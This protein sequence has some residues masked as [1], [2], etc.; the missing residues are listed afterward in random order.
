MLPTPC[1]IQ[2]INIH[3]I[4]ILDFL[5]LS[6]TSPPSLNYLQSSQASSMSLATQPDLHSTC[7][8]VS[9]DWTFW[10]WSTFQSNWQDNKLTGKRYCYWHAAICVS[11]RD[12][13]PSFG[14]TIWS[15]DMPGQKYG[16][17]YSRWSRQYG[18]YTSTFANSRF[19]PRKTRDKVKMVSWE[20]QRCVDVPAMPSPSPL[21]Y[22]HVRRPHFYFR[23]YLHLRSVHCTE[24]KHVSSFYTKMYAKRAGHFR[25][26]LPT[27]M[28][29][30]G[31]H[32][33]EVCILKSMRKF[34]HEPFLSRFLA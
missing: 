4:I 12:S 26:L 21:S 30:H 11:L 24:Y 5:S 6:F 29:R 17:Q 14:S 19:K 34:A 9:E 2:Q 15:L 16:G 27:F 3:D 22:I 10:I 31:S 20:I 25:W 18:S 33:Y 23:L 1:S 8:N 32:R 7:L 28:A 13:T